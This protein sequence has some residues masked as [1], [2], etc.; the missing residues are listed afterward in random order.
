MT[1]PTTTAA[2]S[3]P[4]SNPDTSVR[5]A[6]RVRPL[7]HYETSISCQ[8]CLRYP[9]P[10]QLVISNGSNGESQHSFTFDSVFNEDVPQS[11]VY[12]QCVEPLVRSYLDGYNTTILAYGQT[13]NKSSFYY[14]LFMISIYTFN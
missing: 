7:L 9:Y 2:S 4:A 5:V 10:T 8:K 1:D 14:T 13:G 3:Q 11:Q 6:I 12:T